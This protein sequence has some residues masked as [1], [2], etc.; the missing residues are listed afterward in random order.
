[1]DIE[2][3]IRRHPGRVPTVL[4]SRTCVLRKKKFLVPHET[5]VTEFLHIVRSYI[6]EYRPKDALF[7][8]VQKMLP[9]HTDTFLELYT[10]YVDVDLILHMQVEREEVFGNST[11]S[12]NASRTS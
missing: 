5:T 12:T 8:F 3:L 9:L 11:T 1:M 10:Q 6:T 4:Q 2:G 7:L